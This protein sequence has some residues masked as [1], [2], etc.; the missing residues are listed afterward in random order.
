MELGD[1][2]TKFAHAPFEKNE[3]YI[4]NWSSAAFDLALAFF[5]SNWVRL[6]YL[7][8]P[9]PSC[10]RITSD[11]KNNTIRG[12]TSNP[13]QT[14]T[15]NLTQTRSSNLIQTRT[16][17]PTQTRSSNLTPNSNFQF[18]VH[19]DEVWS[20]KRIWLELGDRMWHELKTLAAQTKDQQ[21]DSSKQPWTQQVWTK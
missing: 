3:G 9:F 21:L 7:H 15:T 13:T 20:R 11:E 1:P 10:H 5:F 6:L 17:N 19:G 14:R 4:G 18:T 8:L 16:T 2:K 12:N